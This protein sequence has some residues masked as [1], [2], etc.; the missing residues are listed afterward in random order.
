M[1]TNY[2]KNISNVVHYFNKVAGWLSAILP[3]MYS[4]ASTFQ[5]FC[6]DLLLS[7]QILRYFRKVYVREKHLVVVA[8]HCKV[9]KIFIPTKIIYSGSDIRVRENLRRIAI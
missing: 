5:G 1:K 4:L 8:N 2:L 3:K 6:S 7:T 9:F